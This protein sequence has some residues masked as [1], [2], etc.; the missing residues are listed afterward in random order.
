M[1]LLSIETANDLLVG[2]VGD[3]LWIVVVHSKVNC[4]LCTLRDS[5][6]KSAQNFLARHATSWFSP[7]PVFFA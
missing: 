4:H 3:P 7:F 1:C 5:W 2:S 6:P